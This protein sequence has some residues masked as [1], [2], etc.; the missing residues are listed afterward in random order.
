M[1]RIPITVYSVWFSAFLLLPPL[2][3]QVQS[4]PP[5]IAA[6]LIVKLA[7]FEKNISASRP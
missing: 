4:A 3:S 2:F 6:S 7:A 1:K 5:N